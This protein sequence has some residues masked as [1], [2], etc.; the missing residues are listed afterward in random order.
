MILNKSFTETT[1]FL[2]I[3]MPTMSGWEFLEAFERFDA[4]IKEQYN[5]YILSSSVNI[6]DI[7]AAKANPLVI[8]FLEKPLNQ[9]MLAK[10]F[11][12]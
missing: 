1:L 6:G 8:G 10:I 4:L 2:D 11:N 7:N 9:G 3:N 5:I 12:G